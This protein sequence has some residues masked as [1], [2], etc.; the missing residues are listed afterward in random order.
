MTEENM[1]LWDAVQQTNPKYAKDAK[2]SGGHRITAICAQSQ[3]MA[4][5]EQW[6]PMGDKWGVDWSL[7]TNHPDL[8]VARVTLYY[9]TS[10]NGSAQ[11][12]HAGSAEWMGKYGIDSEAVKKAVTDGTTKCLSLLGFNA[13]IFLGEY[14]GNKH[15]GDQAKAAPIGII[16]AINKLIK[17]KGSDREKLLEHIKTTYKREAIEDLTLPEA[18]I[19]KGQ[20]ESKPDKEE[21]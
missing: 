10:D 13:D 9:P 6:G 8:C 18:N 21:E 20:L 2:V 12:V 16:N 15:E 17:Q 14:D 19:I 3:I 7:L 4:A 11:I 5:T 1:H